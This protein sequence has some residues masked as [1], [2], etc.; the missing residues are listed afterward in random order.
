MK[1]T[2]RAATNRD[3]EAVKNLVFGILD[4]FQLCSDPG[5]TDADLNDIEAFYAGQGGS[6]DVLINDAGEIVGSVG[7]C[8]VSDGTCELRKM[9]LSRWLRGQGH[10]RQLLEHALNQARALGYSRVVLET[11]LVLKDATRLYEAYGFRPY[12][13]EHKSKRCDAAYVLELDVK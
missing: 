10:G 5:C 12:A 9:Y 11:A 4:E 13:P 7:L 8:G 1:L 2:L 6:F 3:C